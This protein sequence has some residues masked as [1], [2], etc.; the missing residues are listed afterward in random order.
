MLR[1]INYCACSDWYLLIISILLFGSDWQSKG[2]LEGAEEYF[3][4]AILANPGDGEIMSQYAKL[5][6]ELHHDHDKA[7]CY[8][9]QAV[10][11]SPADR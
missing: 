1:P 8:F 4:R 2:D 10:Q 11:D 6:W 9:E 7:L 3:S 5:V